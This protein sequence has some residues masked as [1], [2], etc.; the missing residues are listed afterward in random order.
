MPTEQEFITTNAPYCATD[1][2]LPEIFGGPTAALSVAPVAA[3]PEPLQLPDPKSLH[4]YR[5]RRPR[6]PRRH[7]ESTGVWRVRTQN[8]R[9][10]ICIW[11]GVHTVDWHNV[12]RDE[13]GQEK[14]VEH[15]SRC[16][17][18]IHRAAG[19]VP[20]LVSKTGRSSWYRWETIR[21]FQRR[22]SFIAA[23][24]AVRELDSTSIALFGVQWNQCSYQQC[25]ETLCEIGKQP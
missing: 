15:V 10:L 24:I 14:L 22:N 13:F 23:H 16:R 7:I 20:I 6:Q 9:R 21:E 18:K 5:K 8:D 3:D 19:S 12:E 1:E 17:V 4:A 11:S 25:L 2:D